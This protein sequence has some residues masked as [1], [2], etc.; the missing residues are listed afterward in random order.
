MAAERYFY[1]TGTTSAVAELPAGIEPN[2]LVVIDFIDAS[3][4]AGTSPVTLDI[5]GNVFWRMPASANG[6]S[7]HLEFSGGWPLWTTSDTDAVPMAA[8]TITFTPGTGG[9]ACSLMV[10]FHYERPAVRRAEGQ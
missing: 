1:V 7:V 8:P 5:E 6:A 10:G 4:V 3:G 9:T 2:K